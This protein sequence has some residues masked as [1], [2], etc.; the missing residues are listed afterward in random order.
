MKQTECAREVKHGSE[1]YYYGTGKC[2]SKKWK[3]FT[4]IEQEGSGGEEMM[5]NEKNMYLAKPQRTQRKPCARPGFKMRPN[6][7]KQA[8]LFFA[9]S[10]LPSAP[11][12][13]QQAAPC[14][15]ES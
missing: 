6:A 8:H 3:K 5:K 2:F 12:A 13:C 14:E 11:A 10:G 4:D 1:L 7:V 9:H 15:G